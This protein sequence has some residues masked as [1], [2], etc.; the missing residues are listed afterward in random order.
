[1]KQKYIFP[2]M[3]ITGIVALLFFIGNIYFLINSGTTDSLPVKTNMEMVFV[4]RGHFLMGSDK[5]DRHMRPPHKVFLDAFWIDQT[6]VTNAQYIQCVEEGV[7]GTPHEA[8]YFKDTK[9]S[10]HPVIYVSWDEALTFCT[11]AGKR[12]PTEAEWE[13]AARGDDGRTYPWGNSK[14]NS[15]LLNYWDNKKGSTEVGSY[16]AGESPYGAMDL[17]GNVWEWTSDWY[18]PD[19][20]KTSPVPNPEGPASG[21]RRIVRG[22]SWFSLTE[23]VVRTYYR[24]ASNPE[25]QNYTTGFRCVWRK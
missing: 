19:F 12:L 15:G 21:D 13:K 24:K 23:I 10:N 2:L 16:P 18:S 25:V 20:Y 1:M 11:W 14:P 8:D 17:A 9:Y 22:G 7:C 3:V 4:P 6:E 5:S